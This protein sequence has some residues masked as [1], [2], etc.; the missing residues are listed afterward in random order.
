MAD[1]QRPVPWTDQQVETFLGN[2]LRT[3]VILSAAAV[4][5]GAAIY[6]VRHGAEMPNY[7]VFRGEPADL[8]SVAGIFQNVLLLSGRGILQFGF[9]LLIG[10]PL[11][12]V[13]MSLVVFTRQRDG[14]YVVF[15]LIVLAVLVYSLS[16]W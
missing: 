15:T 7:E 6:L 8:R 13:A 2:V 11:M 1:S 16:G 5:L 12:R 14:A 4:A 10:T 9:L 3:G